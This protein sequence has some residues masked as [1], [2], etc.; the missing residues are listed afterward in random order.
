[1]SLTPAAG[2]YGAPIGALSHTFFALSDPTRRD[3]L[4]RLAR[5]EAT[6]SD[7]AQAHDL[8]LNGIKKHISIL[9]RADLVATEKIGRSRHC[10]LGPTG[11]GEAA[12]WI[13]VHRRAWDDRMDRFQDFVERA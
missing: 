7:L 9:E 12:A 5:S 13:D 4:E 8:T 1:M 6:I 2:C 10:R 11:L 3:I